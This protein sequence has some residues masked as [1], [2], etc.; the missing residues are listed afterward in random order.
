MALVLF[1]SRQAKEKGE[2]GPTF[3]P[4][5]EP[6]SVTPEQRQLR[7]DKQKADEVKKRADYHKR[8]LDALQQILDLQRCNA[9]HPLG[10]DRHHRR[11]WLFPAL[12]AFMVESELIKRPPFVDAG[13]GGFRVGNIHLSSLPTA[14]HN[15]SSV[16]ENCSPAV[17]S[18]PQGDCDNLSDNN[19]EGG[20]QDETPSDNEGSLR[21]HPD[22]VS[23]GAVRAIARD[24]CSGVEGDVDMTEAM[25]D[26]SDVSNGSDRNYVGHRETVDRDSGGWVGLGPEQA[27]L[28]SPASTRWFLVDS[29][30]MFAEL[31][32]SFNRRGFRES[33]LLQYL[34]DTR[35]LLELLIQACPKSSL[36]LDQGDNGSSAERRHTRA[37]EPLIA[38]GNTLTDS[39]SEAMEMTLRDGLLDLEDRIFVGSLGSM[40]V[41]GFVC[42]RLYCL[43]MFRLWLCPFSVFSRL[44]FLCRH[45]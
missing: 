37:S 28:R 8:E 23:I 26:L 39:A 43:P 20:D 6:A 27:K 25:E 4:L 5:N 21:Q 24:G 10:R 35:P 22:D 7:D 18:T 30:T 1:I 38:D 41:S 15:I 14:N 32:E 44:Q 33:C 29:L 45:P 36:C 40:K 3:S 9:L 12:P 17:N 2:K 34:Q 42:F 11:Y 13:G 19:S 16:N 31:L